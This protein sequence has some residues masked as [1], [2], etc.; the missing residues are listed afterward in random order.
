MRTQRKSLPWRR[1]GYLVLICI[2][3]G[4]SIP[5]FSLYLMIILRSYIKHVNECFIR[6]P[7]ISKWL[8]KL[9]MSRFST[10]FSMFGHPD[11]TLFLVFDIVTPNITLSFS[12]FLPSFSLW[13]ILKAFSNK[14]SALSSCPC[15]PSSLAFAINLLYF[16]LSPFTPSVHDSTVIG[17]MQW[18]R[19]RWLF[20]WR[21]FC[22]I[23]IYNY[24][25]T[26]FRNWFLINI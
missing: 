23:K 7:N 12:I 5:L 13:C 10:L 25:L 3:F 24:Q 9:F 18:R 2:D 15:L 8:K 4:N 21:N 19:L 20:S 11:E 1:L 17:K 16:A 6:H 14:P 22:R 26:W